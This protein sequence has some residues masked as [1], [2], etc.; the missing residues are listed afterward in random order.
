MSLITSFITITISIIRKLAKSTGYNLLVLIY[1]C[2]L[3]KLLIKTAKMSS[4]AVT[5]RK[6]STC[7]IFGLPAD[8]RANALPTYKHVMLSYLLS[9]Q[10]MRVKTDGK[11]LSL[12]EISENLAHKIVGKS[13]DTYCVS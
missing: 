3:I 2:L 13:I 6:K 1:I 9:M 12:K 4:A 8:L 5:T 7:P 10:K 11:Q